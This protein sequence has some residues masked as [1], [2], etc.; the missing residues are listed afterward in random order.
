[1]SS[2]DEFKPFPHF[3]TNALHAGQDFTQWKSHAVVPP[4]SLSTTFAQEE[5]GVHTGYEYSR[6]GNPTRDVLEK[7]IAAL[8][9]GKHCM[10]FSSGLG[11]T[12]AITHMLKAGDHIVAMND[13]YGGTNRYFR[14][15]ASKFGLETS[16]VDLTN[17]ANLKPAMKPNTKMIWLETPTNPTMQ[18]VDVKACSEIA[19][20][21]E[22]VFVVVDNTFM[23]PY[24][25]RPL[26]LGGDIS[27]HSISKYI[28][29][30]SDVIMGVAVTNSDKI[31]EELRFLQ[32]AIGPVPAPFD[33]YMVNR[34]IKTLHVR[35]QAHQKNALACARFLES[36][37]AVEKVLHPGLPSHPQY[38][39]GKRQMQGYSGMITFYVKGG[40]KEARDFLKSIKVFTLAESLGGY[41]SLAEHPAIMTHASIVKEEREAL[42]ITDNLIRLSVGIEDCDDLVNDLAQ[43][44]KIAVPSA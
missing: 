43:A 10:V 9:N 44:L 20:T 18:L 16:F 11:A 15:V 3:A 37:P 6:S 23:S 19:H 1:M 21:Q 38:E 12:T 17:P 42:G 32:N 25:Q 7:C 14:K 34:G 36:S 13:L 39:L 31:N 27:F 35:M 24:F 5:P 40:E 41:E 22:G 29:G 26:D 28:N 33:C 30:H 4:I 8:E 2:G